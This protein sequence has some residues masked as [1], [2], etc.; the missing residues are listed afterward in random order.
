MGAH[1][2]RVCA[3]QACGMLFAPA[4]V[5]QRFCSSQ[6]RKLDWEEEHTVSHAKRV[7]TLLFDGRWHTTASIA[8]VGGSAGLRRLREFRKAVQEGKHLPFIDLLKE[9]GAGAQFRYR[10]I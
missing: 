1:A 9:R 3:F 2:P 8:A 4:R 10:L 5:W 7:R 6:C